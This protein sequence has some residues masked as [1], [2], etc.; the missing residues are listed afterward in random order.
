MENTSFIQLGKIQR[1]ILL[2]I[3]FVLAVIL[4]FMRIGLKSDQPL[5]LL[6]RGSLQPEIALK[7]GKPTIIEFYAD[8]CEACKA[9]ATTM[10]SAKQKYKDEIDI[11]LLNVDNEKWLDLIDK[12]EVKGIP[13]LALFDKGGSLKAQLIGLK[14]TDQI[15]QLADS[16]LSDQSITSSLSDISNE[17]SSTIKERIVA[18]NTSPRSHS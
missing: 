18:K 2:T 10:L 13:Q 1:I 12:Y 14:K 5:D 9:M 17:L 6:A 15:D 8:W 4:F 16:L 11:V 3:S 7:N